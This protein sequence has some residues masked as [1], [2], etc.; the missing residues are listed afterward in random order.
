MKRKRQAEICHLNSIL[1]IE[2]NNTMPAMVNEPS[3]VNE[4]ERYGAI[5]PPLAYLK[6]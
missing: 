6:R 2:N 4:E 3:A 5:P 1:D